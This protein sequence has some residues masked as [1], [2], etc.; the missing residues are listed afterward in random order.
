M[1]RNNLY[2]ELHQ[3]ADRTARSCGQRQWGLR[4][5]H[6]WSFLHM[7]WSSLHLGNMFCLRTGYSRRMITHRLSFR[8][9][10][11]NAETADIILRRWNWCNYCLPIRL[12][13]YWTFLQRTFMRLINIQQANRHS[14][15]PVINITINFDIN[16]MA[17]C[18]KAIR[19]VKARLP[20]SK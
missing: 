4:P 2:N 20:S 7:E 12:N 17:G 1:R 11:G 15:C 16:N 9:C 8:R 19:A 18:Q 13:I 10:H 3:L 6:Q 14:I 5:S